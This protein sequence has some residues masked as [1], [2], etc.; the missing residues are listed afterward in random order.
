MNKKKK[1]DNIINGGEMIHPDEDVVTK[2]NKG[3]K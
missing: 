2:F 3:G 1:V